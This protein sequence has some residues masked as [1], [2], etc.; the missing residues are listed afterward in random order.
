M[1]LCNNAILSVLLL[2]V[3]FFCTGLAIEPYKIDAEKNARTHNNKG[4][5]YLKEN[6]Y[7]AAIEEF[8]IAVSLNPNTQASST[9]YNNLGSTYLK[10]GHPNLAENCFVNALHYS[11][12]TFL[13]YQNLVESYK[14]QKVVPER[15]AKLQASTNP[16]SKITIGL[17][18]ME[19][20]DEQIGAAVLSEFAN[21]EP[22]LIITSALKKYVKAK[23]DSL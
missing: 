14:Q 15:L 4:V 5:V 18:Y 17:I 7:F 8:K 16:L 1:K 19:Q 20:G 21:S 12:M 23:S 6:M 11:P 22:D 13:Y 3:L 10:I 2:V 9:F